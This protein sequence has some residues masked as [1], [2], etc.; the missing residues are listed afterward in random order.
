MINDGFEWVLI[1]VYGPAHDERK[2]EFLEEI[3]IKI[4]ATESLL[5]IGAD[6]N[7]VRKVE[8]KSSR[9]VDVGLMDAFNGMINVTSLRELHRS[10]SRFTWSNKQSPQYC[11]FLIE[12]WSPILGKTSLTWH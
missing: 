2:L 5:I 9:N 6:F 4:L 8:E 11:V 7:L 1:N 12:F 3:Q 10:G